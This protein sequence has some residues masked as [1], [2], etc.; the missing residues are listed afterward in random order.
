MILYIIFAALLCVLA[1]LSITRKLRITVQ[2]MRFRRQE[3]PRR[4]GNSSPFRSRQLVSTGHHG[5]VPHY[6][7]AVAG[8]QE[9][10]D[11]G[12]V[13]DGGPDPDGTLCSGGAIEAEDREDG[14]EEVPNLTY[15]HK[16]RM[17]GVYPGAQSAWEKQYGVKL[18]VFSDSLDIE[19]SC[20]T[21]VRVPRFTT[22]PEAAQVMPVRPRK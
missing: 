6:R 8:H 9:D 14:V 4:Q 7:G 13:D 20:K 19:E 1:F 21:R 18:D 10:E 15:T 3:R 2:H 12:F 5:A 11:A 16:V 22:S 17:G